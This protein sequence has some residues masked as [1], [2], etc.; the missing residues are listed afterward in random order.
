MNSSNISRNKPI[1]LKKYEYELL[2][3][4]FSNQ[5]IKIGKRVLASKKITMG[6]H[7]RNF[8]KSFAKKNWSE[9]CFDG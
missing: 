7:T 4:G 9:V 3:N 1:N 2:E 8:E 5:D 6:H